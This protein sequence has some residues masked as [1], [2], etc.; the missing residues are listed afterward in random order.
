M[1]SPSL[2]ILALVLACGGGSDAV[3][4][5]TVP[6]P[7]PPPPTPP[8]PPPPPPTTGAPAL[9]LVASGLSTPILVTAPPGDSR[10]F[11]VE[12]NGR[13]RIVANG[14]LRS[15]PF[16]DL[17]GRV[18]TG[19]EQGLLGLAFH[20]DFA[21][22]RLFHVNFTDLQGTTRVVAFRAS[23]NDPDQADLTSEREV[24]AVAQPFGNH[25][26]G[27]LLYGPDGMLYIGMGDGGSG[28]DPQGNG[29]NSGTLLGSLLRFE[30]NPGDGSLAVPI[31]NPFVGQVGARPELWSIGLRNPWRFAFDP[32][33]G[34]LYI[35]DVGQNAR[36]E[37]NVATAAS[38]GG[39]G[40]NFGWKIMEGSGCFAPASGCNTSGL[41]LPVL[42]Y[43]H[44][45]GCSITGGV[46]YRGNAVAM[47]AGHYLYAD[48]C[49]G[50]VRSF[51]LVG[52]AVQDAT[53]W[54]ALAPPGGGVTSFGVDAAGEAYLMTS[55][56]SVYQVVLGP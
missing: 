1:K 39:R 24:L 44:A 14:V 15:E 12:K 9:R 16:L 45:E 42:E 29:Q 50:W 13:I 30:V 7:A 34:D 21:T 55:G 41:T 36:E 17:R 6:P 18:S 19:S 32:A 10:L 47:L 2:L 40:L 8:P 31:D 56:G 54:P 23:G 43:S 4:P 37:V 53:T 3:T 38:G 51:R 28:G 49:A 26:G 52:G 22:T 33:N 25:N 48:F 46:V 27:H 5:P 35:G 20:P 11:I